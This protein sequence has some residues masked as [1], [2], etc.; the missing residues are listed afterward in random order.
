MPGHP[1]PVGAG[2]DRGPDPGGLGLGQQLAHSRQH[3]QVQGE[4]LTRERIRTI[5]SSG[6]P[7]GLAEQLRHSIGAQA[8]QSQRGGESLFVE[9]NAEVSAL[10]T[11]S[12]DHG[13]FG[14]DDHPVEIQNERAVFADAVIVPPISGSVNIPI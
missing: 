9:R 14:V 7:P 12:G 10:V 1:F 6:S 8:R 11:P 3:R 4:D 13:R 2:G 5:A